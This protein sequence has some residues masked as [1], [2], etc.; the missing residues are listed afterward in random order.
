M[1]RRARCLLLGVS[2]GVAAIVILESLGFAQT[3]KPQADVRVALVNGEAIALSEV[4]AVLK[5][6]PIPLTAPTAGQLR[7]MRLEVVTALIDDLL[8]R[9]FMRD[10]G[11]KVDPAEIN[12]QVAALEASLKGKGKTFA[13]Y[14]KENN[15]TE[16]QLKASMLLLLQLDRYVKQHTTD[17]DLKKYWEANKDYFDKTTV[18]TSHI[19]IRLSANSTPGEREKA[20]QKLQALRADIIAGKIEFAAAAKEHSQCPSAPKGGDIGFIF[21]KFQNVEEAY[22]KAAFALK[23]GDISEVVE[24][25]FGLHLIKVTDRKVGMPSKFEQCI[26]DVRDSYAEEL[27]IAL[28]NQLRKKAKV[29]ITLP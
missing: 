10:Q 20:K 22:A 9:Q 3:S 4:D 19:V 12:R 5:Q 1:R 14:L 15:Q 11:P 16:A 13:D 26:E 21:R 27:R 6:R 23:V 24:T 25:D 2:I 28:L 29:E 8:V 17:A 18:R 7:Q